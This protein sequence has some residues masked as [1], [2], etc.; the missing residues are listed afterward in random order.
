MENNEGKFKDLKDK[1]IG[2]IPKVIKPITPK[3]GKSN[4]LRA[5]SFPL[6]KTLIDEGKTSID[7]E[8]NKV[9]EKWDG[10]PIL[11]TQLINEYEGIIIFYNV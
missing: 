4:S 11:N 5:M 1:V 9:L 10:V 7:D 6:N 2:V 3:K 8:V